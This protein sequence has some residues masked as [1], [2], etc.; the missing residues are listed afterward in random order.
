MYTGTL[1]YLTHGHHTVTTLPAILKYIA[2][3]ELANTADLNGHLAKGDR[4]KNTAWAA[5]IESNL[6]SFLVSLC[7]IV[8][9]ASR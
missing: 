3:S 2:N 7:T 5:H 4:A 9:R 1:P 6:G 8:S